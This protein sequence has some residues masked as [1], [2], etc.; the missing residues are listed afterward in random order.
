MMRNSNLFDGG[1][2]QIKRIRV[3]S[4]KLAYIVE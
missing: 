1:W 4:G 2:N 3:A